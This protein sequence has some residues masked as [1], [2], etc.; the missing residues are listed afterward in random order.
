MNFIMGWDEGT[1]VEPDLMDLNRRGR[2][3]REHYPNAF[4]PS[5]FRWATVEL[6]RRGP[7]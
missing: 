3:N 7:P 2:L 5:I 1:A 6:Y 4:P